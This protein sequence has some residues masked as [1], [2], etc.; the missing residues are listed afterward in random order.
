VK[1]V[2]KRGRAFFSGIVIYHLSHYLISEY[3]RFKSGSAKLKEEVKQMKTALW[4]TLL[5][6]L[7]TSSTLAT[8]TTNEKNTDTQPNNTTQ[9]SS[10]HTAMTETTEKP[11]VTGHK[12][13]SSELEVLKNKIGIYE[14]DQNYSQMVDGYGTGMLPPTESEWAEI[15]ASL[16]SIDS[17]DYTVEAPVAAVDQSATPWFPP[18]GNQGSQGSCVAWSV[19]YYVK[20]FQEAK[21]REWDLTGASWESGQPTLSYQNMTISPA[22]VYNLI[23]G[24]EDHGSSFYE[25]I[26][27]VC[28]VGASSW[29]KMPYAVENCTMWPSEAAWTEAAFYRG[30]SSGYQTM[31]VDSDGGVSN[32]MNWIASGNLAIIGVDANKYS[33]LTSTDV[34]TLEGYAN[35]DVNHANTIVGYDDS[36]SYT[37]NGT[38]HYG[39]FKVANSWGVGGRWENVPDGFYWISYETMKQR[40]GYC[41]FYHDMIDYEPELLAAFQISHEKRSEC[42]IRIGLGNPNSAMATKSFSQ[43]V[44]GGEVPFPENSVVLDVTEFTSY[45]PT[46][47]GQSFFLRVYDG[48]TSTIGNVTRFA[49]NQEESENAPCQTEP[50]NAVY[51]TVTPSPQGRILINTNSEPS[52]P[53]QKVVAGADV[54]LFFTQVE[55]TSGQFRLYMSSNNLSEVSAGDVAYTPMFDLNDLTVSA[56]T[57]YSS[58]GGVWQVGYNWVNGTTP[59]NV[60]GGE[61][62]FKAAA[63]SSASVLVSDTSV[64]LSGTLH[65]TPASGPAGSAI[66]VEG[67]GFSANSTADLAYLNPITATWV[68]VVN[69]TLVDAD[70]HFSYGTVGP[71]LTQNQPAGDNSQL[72]DQIIFQ[73]HDN[74]DGE[75]YN[76]TTP[77]NEFRRGLTQVGGA[78]ALGLFGNNTDLTSLTTFEAGASL[79]VVGRWFIPGSAVILWNGTYLDT[80]TVDSTGHFTKTFTVPATDSEAQTTITISNGNT[81]FLVTVTVSPA[82][83]SSDSDESPSTSTNPSPSPTPTPS[84]SPTPSPAP[85]PVPSPSPQPTPTPEPQPPEDLPMLPY[86][87]AITAVLSLIVAVAF[88]LKKTW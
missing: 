39:A 83:S 69:S 25:A 62:F 78:V 74:G 70:G 22:F 27:L 77:F 72:L 49:V 6:L 12:I 11:R 8:A 29:E 81:D 46:V 26:R 65:V 3:L 18:I 37:E 15:G 54:N 73:A 38:T 51:L 88:L 5:L 84:P 24:G 16:Y 13:T 1:V 40:I 67:Y 80:A 41:M 63:D 14:A 79:T 43:Y 59:T 4:I 76:A 71:D 47:Y 17:V 57:A 31:S 61:H 86:I 52:V 68:S 34:W 66:T 9:V 48:G 10:T 44:D 30:N 21:E 42:N 45:V 20:T 82:P 23:N 87:L 58:A 35:P 64:L 19:G 36:V 2:V 56:V 53:N 75:H 7:I 55:W 28:F 50:S 32:L 85:T 60:A 33:A